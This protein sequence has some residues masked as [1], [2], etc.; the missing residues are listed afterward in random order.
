MYSSV[1]RE[2]SSSCLSTSCSTLSIIY[3]KKTKGDVDNKN[4][5]HL[6]ASFAQGMRI[7]MWPDEF[8]N[9]ET[10]VLIFTR[11]LASFE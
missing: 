11:N 8:V 1:A 2:S 7:A 10:R 3:R 9:I 4:D 6:P 5:R